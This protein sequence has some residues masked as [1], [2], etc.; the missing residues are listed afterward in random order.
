[1]I[2]SCI[3][4]SLPHINNMQFSYHF[5]L[6]V[7]Q[8]Y[9]KSSLPFN[10][11][12]M[13]VNIWQVPTF[14]SLVAG[15]FHFNVS[16][17]FFLLAFFFFFFFSFFIIKTMVFVWNEKKKLPFLLFTFSFS[18]FPVF[19]RSVVG[20]GGIDLLKLVLNQIG[21]L[22]FFYFFLKKEY[23]GNNRLPKFGL[24]HPKSGMVIEISSH[25]DL[26]QGWDK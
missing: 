23:I 24:A 9:N 14:K 5:S 4:T 20:C 2:T 22:I 16:L 17:P 26:G 3:N 6:K 11:L 13:L 7:S 8:L 21:C 12:S 10:I 25:L 1:M 15:A 19:G 18:F